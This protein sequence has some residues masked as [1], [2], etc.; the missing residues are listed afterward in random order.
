MI[1]ATA[2]TACGGSDDDGGSSTTYDLTGNCGENVTF[3]YSDAKGVL[4]IEGYGAMT[5][6]EV[7]ELAPWHRYRKNIKTIL[8]GNEI[9]NIGSSAFY[10]CPKLT[11]ITLPSSVTSIGTDAFRSCT[12]L[13]SITFPIN[14]SSIG[15]WAFH[16]CGNLTSITSLNPTPP[17][18][19]Y[20]QYAG[21]FSKS[22]YET[23]TLKVPAGSKLAYQR[24]IEWSKFKNIEEI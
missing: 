11:S 17:T 6:Y 18:I 14:L 21:V 10:Y 23:A 24:A 2:I 15:E 20:N 1:A 16:S 12:N 5:N 8:I 9:R 22:I 3:K 19:K 13:T 4:L 7:F